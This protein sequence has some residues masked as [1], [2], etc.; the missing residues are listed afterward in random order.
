MSWQQKNSRCKWWPWRIVRRPV[1]I[2]VSEHLVASAILRFNFCDI[3]VDCSYSMKCK[4]ERVDGSSASITWRYGEQ[5]VS[6]VASST[7]VPHAKRKRRVSHEILS[8]A[9]RMYSPVQSGLCYRTKRRGRSY[10]CD[11][12]RCNYEMHKVYRCLTY[13]QKCT[14]HILQHLHRRFSTEKKNDFENSFGCYSKRTVSTFVSHKKH[15]RWHFGYYGNP[16]KC[17]KERWKKSVKTI[18]KKFK[19]YPFQSKTQSCTALSGKYLHAVW[20][21]RVESLRILMPSKIV[22]L[23]P[24]KNGY[25]EL[26]PIKLE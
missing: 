22:I 24:S 20:T 13:L 8:S 2:L 1:T 10:M 26:Q 14:Y 23:W 17:N 9:T 7:N 25:S 18:H 11:S 3:F 6:N 5:R 4:A 16:R 12:H 19:K 15:G 21:C